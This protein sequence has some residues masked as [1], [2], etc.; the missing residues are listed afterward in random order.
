MVYIH[1]S[2]MTNSTQSA[3]IQNNTLT[4]IILYVYDIYMYIP[5]VMLP[6]R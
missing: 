6:G 1:I 2:E 3:G 5:A 4:Y